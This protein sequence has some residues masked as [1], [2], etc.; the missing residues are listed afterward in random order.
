MQPDQFLSDR[1]GKATKTRTSY[2][3]FVPHPLPPEI[4]YSAEMIA[5]LAEAERA[6][7]E[8]SGI[9]RILPNPHMLVAPAVRHEAVL[10]SR[11]EGTHAGIEDLFFFEAEPE[12]A[13]DPSDVREVANYV[14]ALEYGLDRLRSLPLS[15]RL[16]REIHERLMRGVRGDA[17]RPG[18]F[19]TTQNWIGPPGCTLMEATFVPPPPPEMLEALDALEKYLHRENDLTPP[20]VRLALI[21]SQ[22]ETI[23]PFADGN[24]RVGRL[25]L[26]LLLVHWGLLPLPLLYLSAF[27]ERHREDYYRS[28]LNVGT[29][30]DWEGWI[31]FF[32]RGV[33]A[34]A[35]GAAATAHRLLE[36]QARYRALLTGKRTPKITLPLMESLF[37]HPVVTAPQVRD[38]WQV[39]FRTAL[40]AIEEL[41]RAGILLEVTGQRRNRAWVAREILD[42]V[43]AS[44]AD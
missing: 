39:N 16:I 25:L 30:G 3:A 27:F 28:L 1:A 24:G 9:G 7:G 42:I 17:A 13:A 4:H 22:F 33:R 2:W 14:T 5:V 31:V 12:S 41:A 23:H 36:T 20:L 37:T 10:S 8:L 18:E 21:H 32:L 26:I 15:L 44:P 43:S 38:R 11:I 34:Q 6:L 40:A 35:L 29:R 19:R